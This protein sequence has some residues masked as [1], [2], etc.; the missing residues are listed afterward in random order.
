V[1]QERRSR[2]VSVAYAAR[3][4][5]ERRRLAYTLE[6]AYNA[7]GRGEASQLEAYQSENPQITTVR[8][9]ALRASMDYMG[10]MPSGWQMVSRLLAQYSP[11]LLLAGEGFGLGG[12]GSVRGAPERALHGDSGVSITLEGATPA[13]LGGLRL[14]AFLDAGAIKSDMD[15]TET[16]R[17]RDRLASVGLGLRYA[18]PGG[19]NLTADYGYV[20]L[21]SRVNLPDNQNPAPQKGDDK[22]H[23]SLTYV[24]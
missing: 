18:H 21:G 8:W 9:K 12:V 5:E 13:M 16:R 2:P 14:A 23:L 20:V 7:G 17:S 24:F 15:N 3:V 4:E 11:D 1:A 6:F 19:I 10:E 22:L